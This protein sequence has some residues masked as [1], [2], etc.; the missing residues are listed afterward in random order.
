LRLVPLDDASRAAIFEA[1]MAN[2]ADEKV[3]EGE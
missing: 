3:R 1:K 2:F